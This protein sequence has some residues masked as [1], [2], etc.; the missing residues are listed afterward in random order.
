MG[1]SPAGI[2]FGAGSV[3]VANSG[4]GT[5]TR[6]DPNTRPAIQATIP[7]GGSPQALTVADGRVWVTVDAQSIAP[8]RGGSGGG[9]L[10][11]VTSLDLDSMDPALAYELL[12]QQLLYATCAQLVNYPDKAGPA[13]SQLTAEVAQSLPTRSDDGRTYKFKIRPGFR[14]SPPS[15]QPVTAQTFKDSIERTL[16]QPDDEELSGA[17]DFQ[18]DIVGMSA[19]RTGKA[20]QKS[21]AITARG[22]TLVDPPSV[23]PRPPDLALRPPLQ[24]PTCA[25]PSDTPLD[26][27]GVRTLPSAGPTTLQS[28]HPSGKAVVLLR[29]PNY[30]WWQPPPTSSNGSRSRSGCRPDEPWRQVDERHR[31]LH[32][33]RLRLGQRRAVGKPRRGSVTARR[34][35]RARQLSRRMKTPS[36]RSS[37]LQS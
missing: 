21:P 37:T 1:L 2:A 4:A 17:V 20:H 19:Y 5:G 34:R 6:I 9:T 22:D 7:V 30:R 25:V 27:N 35:V 10:R 12:S 33:A 15:D 14:F 31:R 24:P 23:A 29:N 28:V 16:N 3:W 8:N 13:G 11:L 18:R 36:V 32:V 26:P